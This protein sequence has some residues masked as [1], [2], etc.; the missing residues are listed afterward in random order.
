[1]RRRRFCTM[2]SLSPSPGVSV[3]DPATC[4]LLSLNEKIQLVRE[5]SKSPS[6]ALEQIQEWTCREIVEI[7]CVELRRDIKY[8]GLS[9]LKLLDVLFKFVKGKSSGRRKHVEKE[10]NPEPDANNIQASSK[11]QRKNDG[12][13][14]TRRTHFHAMGSS[15][16]FSRALMVS[17]KGFF[18]DLA[19]RRLMS[20]DEKRELI[21]ELAKCNGSVP[22]QLQE[23]TRCEIIEVLCAEL[24][25]ERTFSSLSKQAMLN[26]LF[27]VVKGESSYPWKHKKKESNPVASAVNLQCPS[28]RQKNNDSPLSLPVMANTSHL[29]QNS[30]CRATLNPEDK[31]CKRCSCCICFKYDDNKDPTLWLFCNSDKPFQESSC[32]FSCHLECA[33][34]DERSGILQIGQPKKLDGDYFCTYCGKQNDLLGCWK[35]Q[36][37][38]AKNARRLDVLC[39]RIFLSHKI[40]ISTKKYMLLHEIVDAAMKKLEAEVGPITGIQDMGHGL[41]GRLA[42]GAEVQKLCACAIEALHS[43]PSGSLTAH[44]ETQRSSKTHCS[45]PISKLQNIKYGDVGETKVDGLEKSPGSS[46][47]ALDEEQ[48]ITMPDAQEGL[49]RKSSTLMVYNRGTLKQNLEMIFAR[50][51]TATLV[52]TGN[53]LVEP[54]GC[55]GS[56]PNILPRGTVNPKELGEESIEEA[57]SSDHVLQNGWLKSET[58]PESSSCKTTSGRFEKNE[59]KDGPSEPNTTAQGSL[60]WESSSLIRNNRGTLQ[61]LNADAA[62]LENASDA[63][64]GKELACPHLYCESLL[65]M[66]E[67]EITL[68]DEIRATSFKS[69]TDYQIPQSVPSKLETGPESS[70][71]KSLPC[72]SQ[73]IS[74]NDGPSKASYQYCVKAIRRLECEGYIE[75]SFRLKFLTW[76][77]L[78]ATPH[79]RRMVGVFVDTLINDPVNLAR[80]LDDAFSDVIYS[81][82][83]HRGPSGFCM[84]LGH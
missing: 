47:A 68:G 10:S 49:L 28:K 82:R 63:R 34:K 27:K 58:G 42:V 78:R 74:H 83:P 26:F 16:L 22:E 35:K 5:M 45:G 32:G 13:S 39:H 36:L 72:K 57:N 11:R 55:S 84:E 15:S 64:I 4:R 30:A 44:L 31:F 75:A 7:L 38:V 48:E 56:L 52:D 69:D 60:R 53:M 3:P 80:Q 61:N 66:T 20:L 1:M 37:L 59:D 81:K 18:P 73:K 6:I 40:L 14:P 77:S 62:R 79:E 46:V 8:T 70:L 41:V 51:E 50:S 25:R 76:F 19:K 24:G 43:L 29:C 54:P 67:N 21:R 65:P 12:P 2:A 17:F 23:W 9:K 33:L 71:N